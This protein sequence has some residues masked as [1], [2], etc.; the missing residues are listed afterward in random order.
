MFSSDDLLKLM[1]KTA[2]DAVNAS[3]PANMV[4][5]KVIS[6]SPLQIKID[7]KLILTSAQLVLSRNVTDYSLSITVDHT[8]ESQSGGSGDSS[9]AS[10]SHSVTGTKTV[11]VHNALQNGD[12]VI[13]MQVS[14]GQKYIVIDKI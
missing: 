2:V 10:H 7:Q 6:D 3:K 9:F 1:K 8:T 11:T 4:F 12:E 14:G 13:L 5:G